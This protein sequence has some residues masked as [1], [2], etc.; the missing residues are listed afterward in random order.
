MSV[1]GFQKENCVQRFLFSFFLICHLCEAPYALFDQRCVDIFDQVDYGVHDRS[2]IYPPC[3]IFYF[4]WH[5]QQIEG[6]NGL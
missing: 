2:H 5:R 6:T 3:G 1:M 4:P